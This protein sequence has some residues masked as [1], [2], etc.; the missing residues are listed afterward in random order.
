MLYIAH[1]DIDECTE[2]ADGCAQT[3]TDTDGN[4]TCSCDVGYKLANDQHGC[5]GQYIIVLHPEST[6]FTHVHPDIDE[7]QENIHSCNQMCSNVNGSYLCS[8]HPGYI[9]DSD[10]QNCTSKCVEKYT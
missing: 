5:D 1:A 10:E 4:Y 8:C 9:L 7:C 2:G 3:C 6:V